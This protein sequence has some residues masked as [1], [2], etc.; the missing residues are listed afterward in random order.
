M[1]YYVLLI[2][3]FFKVRLYVF[4]Y[5]FKIKNFD[6]FYLYF[7]LYSN[8]FSI[9]NWSDIIICSIWLMIEILNYYVKKL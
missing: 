4:V 7:I 8:G 2:N 3:M 1:F 9:L 6:D 5:V